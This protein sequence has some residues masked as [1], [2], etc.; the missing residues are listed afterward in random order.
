MKTIFSKLNFK[1]GIIMGLG[2]CLYTTIMWLTKLDSTYLKLGQYFDMLIILLPISIILIVIKKENTF[3]KLNILQ[4]IFIAIYVSTI[5]FIIY[6]PFLYCYHNYIN[7]EWFNFVLE[8]KK[9]EL[10]NANISIEKLNTILNDMKVKN[11]NQNK[12]FRLSA[13]IPSVI[14][15]PSIIAFIS[16]VFIRNKKNN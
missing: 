4:R 11:V 15:I 6:G 10:V 16:L 12:I 5:S 3:G 7:P 14:I 1:Y 8:L 13:F 2:F 9:E